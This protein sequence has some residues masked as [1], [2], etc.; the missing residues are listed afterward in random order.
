MTNANVAGKISRRESIG[1]QF[2]SKSKSWRFLVS[3]ALLLNSGFWAARAADNDFAAPALTVTSHANGQIVNTRTIVLQGTATDAG[4]GGHGISAVTVRGSAQ[5]GTA[6]GNAIANWS[7]TITLSAGQNTLY[8]YAY[9]QSTSQNSTS[10]TLTINFQ[11]VD[12]LAPNVVVTSHA[13]GAIVNTKTIVVSGTASDAGYGNNG[14][15]SVYLRGNIPGATATGTGTTTWSR[16]FTLNR[17]AN[18]LYITASDASDV[19][20]QRELNLTINFQPT[21][22]LAPSIE[23]TSH[24]SGQIVTTSTIVLSGT[25]TDAGRGNNGISSVYVKQPLPNSNAAGG[26]TVH[27]SR[28]LDLRPGANHIDVYAYDQSDVSNEARQAVVITFNPEDTQ[29]PILNLT[30]HTNGQ[31]VFTSTIVL[32]GNSTDAGR[33]DKGISSVNLRGTLPNVSGTGSQIVNWSRS[34]QLSPGK[35][36]FTIYAYD[37]NLFP[38]EASQNWIINYQAADTLGP[39]LTLT[40]HTE[41]QT[42][43]TRTVTISGT[44]SDAGRG[45]NGISQVLLRGRIDGATASGGNQVTWSRVVELSPGRNYLYISAYDNSPFPNVTEKTLELLLKPTDS[46][47]PGLQITSHTDGQ[48]ILVN[49]LTLSGTASD[50]G[51]GDNGISGVNVNFRRAENDTAAGA[52]VANWSRT[53]AL[54]PGKN[55]IYVTAQDASPFPQETNVTITVTY[56]IGDVTPPDLTIDQPRNNITVSTSSINVSGTVS[57]SGRGGSGVTGVTVNG[58]AATGGVANASATGT[59]NRTVPLVRGANVI[60]VVALDGSPNQNSSAQ[61][62]TVT[63]EPADVDPPVIEITSHKKGQTVTTGSITL[64][65]TATDAGHGSSSIVSVTVNGTRAAGDTAAGGSTAIWTRLVNLSLG[66]NVISAV[67]RDGQN[68]ETAESITINYDP[69]DSSPPDLVVTSHRKGQTVAVPTILLAG[70]ASDALQGGNGIADVTVNSSPATGGTAAGAAT[71]LWTRSVTLKVGPNII[72]VV[73]HDNSPGRNTAAETLTLVYEPVD[74]TPPEL[75][76]TSHRNG[77]TVL[78]TTIT[79]S[80]TATDKDFGD[81]GVSAVSV[82]NLPS[83]GGTATGGATANWSRTINLVLGEN[84]I[85]VVASDGSPRQNSAAVTLTLIYDPKLVALSTDFCWAVKGGSSG[86]AAGYS[87]ALDTQGNSYVTGSFVGSVTLGGTNLLSRG[88]S[89]IFVAKYDS[90]GQLLWA[91]QAGGTEA[92]VGFGIAVDAAGACHVT[93][94]YIGSADFSGRVLKTT[95]SYDLFVAKYDSDGKLLW[96]TNTGTSVGILGRAIAVDAQGNSYLTGGFRY[97]SDFGDDT[98]PNN[99]F[100]D[101]FVAKYGP[102]GE[103]RWATQL[104]GDDDDVGTSIGVDAQGGCYVTG[105]FADAAFFGDDSLFSVGDSDMFL[106]KFDTEGQFEWVSQAGEVGETQGAAVSVDPHGNCLVAGYFDLLATFGSHSLFSAGFY[107]LFL[108][109]YDPQGNVLWAR[110]TETSNA[111]SA[112][113]VATDGAGNAYLT[114]TFFGPAQF[115][116]LSLANGAAAQIFVAKYDADGNIVWA[117]QAGGPADDVGYAVAADAGGSCVITGSTTG[118]ASFGSRELVGGSDPDLAI[119]RV[120]GRGASYP[121]NLSVQLLSPTTLQLQFNVDSCTSHRLQGS[122]DLLQWTSIPTSTPDAAGGIG[123]HVENLGSENP[124]RFFRLVSP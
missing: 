74:L 38:N 31:T 102:N 103:F 119:A 113:G 4:R 42:V 72:S 67:A 22:G 30:S 60:S 104:G 68:N 69:A 80:G 15:S 17:G 111:I 6:T 91:R 98:F 13:Q 33:G 123:T 122:P 52:G 11:P 3:L 14:I 55:S 50:A 116:A 24:T 58:V 45:D 10:L 28:S 63:Y 47:P 34:L 94:Y 1:G 39:N 118:V 54:N 44:T 92:D 21:D 51:R 77:Q 25:A 106:A 53:F 78:G 108:A 82:N 117:R 71:A 36:Y 120:G 96:A 23:I 79:L 90:A 62:I 27:W 105:Y 73:A 20:N 84:V 57:D 2:I 85:S 86:S 115:G 18:T 66:P 7:Q 41:G 110:N 81:N 49:Y 19:Q 88:A 35:N 61:T 112:A 48:V 87:V 56:Q 114:G 37:G 109:K 29:A 59:W 121:I 9:D 95:G 99:E 93:G 89:D 12:A 32:A 75:L 40:S 65:G 26:G 46:L 70:T 83:T 64:A 124:H 8:L 5:G 107:D 97:E 16:E 43:T 100:N 76:V 101:I